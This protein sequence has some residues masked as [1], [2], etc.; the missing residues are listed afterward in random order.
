MLQCSFAPTCKSLLPGRIFPIQKPNLA[1][2]CLINF[3]FPD[4]CHLLM[5]TSRCARPSANSRRLYFQVMGVHQ[6]STQRRTYSR[7]SL[8]MLLAN[9]R[10]VMS[11]PVPP[12]IRANLLELGM[13]DAG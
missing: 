3:H 5:L 10:V 7:L 1:L 8:S 9:W 6:K 11:S 2:A 12:V 4:V 13:S